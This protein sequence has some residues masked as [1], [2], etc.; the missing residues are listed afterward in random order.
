M[1]TLRAVCLCALLLP[2]VAA[3]APVDCP[4]GMK[5]LAGGSYRMANGDD[6]SLGSF[7]LDVTEVTVSDYARCVEAEACKAEELECGNAATWGKPG[8]QGHPVNCVS[9]F[10]A[11]AFCRAHGK[12]LPTEAEWE[13]AARGGRKAAT[14]PWGEAA[15]ANRVCWDGD[16]NSLGKGERKATCATGAHPKSR[17]ADGL[18]DLSGNVREWTA[19][20]E[21][22]FRVLRGGSWGDSLPEFL[23]AGFRGW[24]APD[25]RMELTGFRCAAELGAKLVVPRRPVKEAK[26]ELRDDGVLVMPFDLNPAPRKKRR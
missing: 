10:E 4:K 12:R 8:L 17:S 15:P 18:Q 3:A 20:E 22:R 7:C 26:A 5:R 23:S 14:F 21:E 9:W 24:N 16:G 13:W 1:R 11:D 6:A 25:E 19:S 2:A